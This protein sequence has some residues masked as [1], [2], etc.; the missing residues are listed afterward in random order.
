MDGKA[1]GHSRQV[2][3]DRE[4]LYRY[5]DGFIGGQERVV[6]R[7]RVGEGEESSGAAG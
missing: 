6:D 3:D 4:A 7:D 1:D 5:G 2:Y